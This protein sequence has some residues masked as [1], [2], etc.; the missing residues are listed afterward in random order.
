MLSSIAPN[1]PPLHYV[2][3]R[4]GLNK[5]VLCEVYKFDHSPADTNRRKTCREVMEACKDQKPWFGIEQEYTLLDY[6]KHPFG[7]PKNGFPGPQ[8]SVQE[9]VSLCIDVRDLI[10]STVVFEYVHSHCARTQLSN[11]LSSDHGK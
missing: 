1:S 7:W 9:D 10:I 3:P 4:G 11:M 5:L 6:D 2:S 8:V